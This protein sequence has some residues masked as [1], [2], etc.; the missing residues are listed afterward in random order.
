MFRF[1]ADRLPVAIILSFSI[2]D[3]S[4]YF[5]VDNIWAL[6][7]FWLLMIIPKGKI[8]AWNHHHQHIPTFRLKILNRLLE[9]F[10]ALHTGVTTNLWL[11]HH[12]LGHHHNYLDQNKD[13]SRWQRKSGAQMG[14][15]E[16]TLNV[17]STAYYRGFQVGKRFPKIQQSFIVYG[18]A[19][20]AVV[21]I[22]AYFKP[23]AT[24]F[25]LIL[26]MITGLLLTAWATY[27]H[28][29]GLS[30]DN[31]FEASRNNLNRFYNI[32]TG[33]LGYHTAHHYKQGT[34]WSL[35]PALH[36]QIKDKIPARLITCAAL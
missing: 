8:C 20:L 12:V 23:L 33:N 1:A 18:L 26:P 36:E 29:S 28:H 13:E 15:I 17:A 30:I 25:L 34:H 4:L 24:L 16:Y 32:T 22:M 6:A 35:L 9:F 2:L 31:E 5:L 10:Y 19:T 11:L 14:E 21:A 3:F 27:E 7:V